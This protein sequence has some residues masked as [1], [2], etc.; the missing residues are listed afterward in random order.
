MSRDG[1]LIASPACRGRASVA[2]RLVG[3]SALAVGAARC[4]DACIRRKGYAVAV[5]LMFACVAVAPILGA[6]ALVVW[7]VRS[8]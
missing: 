8:E 1:L 5:V 7:A 4:D 6:A 3:E 2:V